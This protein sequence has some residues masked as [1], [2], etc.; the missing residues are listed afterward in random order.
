MRNLNKHVIILARLLLVLHLGITGMFAFEGE[1]LLWENNFEVTELVEG[2]EK[3]ADSKEN[4]KLKE[5]D[6]FIEQITFAEQ[7]LKIGIG[8]IESKLSTRV[9][10][11]FD[12][13]PTPPPQQI[14]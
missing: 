6:E 7:C 3:D 12:E 11:H 13:I 10:G 1:G 9:L 5:F 2:E 8:E 14:I 4:N